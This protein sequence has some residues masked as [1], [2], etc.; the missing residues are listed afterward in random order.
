MRRGRVAGPCARTVSGPRA[1]PRRGPRR[2]AGR[3][4]RRPRRPTSPTRHS[5]VTGSPRPSERGAATAA[6]RLSATIHRRARAGVGQERQELLA[7]ERGPARPPRAS[8]R[9]ARSRWRRARRRRLVAAGSLTRLKWSMSIIATDSGRPW[10][11]APLTRPRELRQDVAPVEEP[12]SGSSCSM[13][14]E[15]PRLV[16]ELLLEV[17]RARGRPHARHQLG[18]DDRLDQQILG[19]AAQRLLGVGERQLGAGDHRG[20]RWCRHQGRP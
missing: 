6:R 7:P 4:R 11:R 20:R 1:W 17:L 8:G 18:G 16:D 15:P 13:R 2:R 10:R 9:A 5:T 14:L 19:A 3:A 12:V